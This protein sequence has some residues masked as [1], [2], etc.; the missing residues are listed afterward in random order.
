MK[1]LKADIE[2]DPETAPSLYMSDAAQSLSI[3]DV[4]T[5]VK[6]LEKATAQGG[7][8][9]EDE[10][11]SLAIAFHDFADGTYLNPEA[12]REKLRPALARAP[13]DVS[14]LVMMAVTGTG[15]LRATLN[16]EEAVISSEARSALQTLET[17]EAT[18]TRPLQT[19]PLV[20]LYVIQENYKAALELLYRALAFEPS[21]EFELKNVAY[22]LEALLIADP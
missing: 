10:R 16:G 14:L 17:M 1:R 6:L 12:M 8:T 9:P 5:A 22:Q 2:T 19:L 21:T 7:L 18:K 13:E 4:E 20:N 3:S 15:D 11:L